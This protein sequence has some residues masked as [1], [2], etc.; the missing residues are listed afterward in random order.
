[1]TMPL[2]TVFYNIE[3]AIKEYRRFSQRNLTRADQQITVDQALILNLVADQPELSQKEISELLY[4]DNAAM[5]RMVEG[6]VKKGMINKSIDPADKRRARLALTSKG[7]KVLENIIPVILR[8]REIALKGL[9][10]KEIAML[11][12]ILQKIVRNVNQPNT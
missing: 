10:E 8:N 9:T 4:K 6:M 12:Q 3:R 5:T 2:K 11:V 7:E 1:M